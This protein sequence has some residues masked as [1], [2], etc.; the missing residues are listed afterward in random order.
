MKRKP[1]KNQFD[2]VICDFWF[3]NYADS[4]DESSYCW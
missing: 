1:S 4:L 3:L 2:V